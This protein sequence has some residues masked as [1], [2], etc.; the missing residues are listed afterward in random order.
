MRSDDHLVNTMTADGLSSAGEGVLAVSMLHRALEGFDGGLAQLYPDAHGS[1]LLAEVLDNH[2]LRDIPV[3]SWR[4]A[5]NSTLFPEVLYQER[6][7]NPSMERFWIT[8]LNTPGEKESKSR[9]PGGMS[10]EQRICKTVRLGKAGHK[11]IDQRGSAGPHVHGSA[12]A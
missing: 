12:L 2:L 1:I 10:N 9:S 3:C 4:P 7:S 6:M 8:P 11:R 5:L